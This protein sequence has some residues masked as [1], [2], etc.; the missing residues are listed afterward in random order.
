MNPGK[1]SE[2]TTDPRKATGKLSHIT[3][4]PN[5][6][7]GKHTDIGETASVMESALDHSATLG[8]RVLM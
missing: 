6:R 3:T 7:L 5:L 4:Y 2:R 8:P 1:P